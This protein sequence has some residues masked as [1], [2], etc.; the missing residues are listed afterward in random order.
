MLVEVIYI[1]I[2]IIICF[3]LQ[4]ILLSQSCQ[5]LTLQGDTHHNQWIILILF[6]WGPSINNSSIGFLDFSKQSFGFSLIQL[7]VELAL[8]CNSYP[9]E[10]HFYCYYDYYLLYLIAYLIILELTTMNT[11]QGYI[12]RVQWIIRIFCIWGSSIDNSSVDFLDFYIFVFISL[13]I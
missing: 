7:N 2:K 13:S 11:L 1:V 3:T 12:L 10:N 4:L 6:V 9:G 5:E 8:A